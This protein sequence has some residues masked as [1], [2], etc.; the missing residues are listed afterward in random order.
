[1]KILGLK[2]KITEIKNSTDSFN[3]WLD[4]AKERI[5]DLEDIPV[6]NTYTEKEEKKGWKIHERAWETYDTQGNDLIYK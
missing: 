2:N 3:S 5:N 6:E 1:M 4:I